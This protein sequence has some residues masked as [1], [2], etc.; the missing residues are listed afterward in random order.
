MRAFFDF[1]HTLVDANSD[2]YVVRAL[3]PALFAAWGPK[4]DAAANE[5]RWTAAI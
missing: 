3:D 4:W 1:D 2:T 5:G